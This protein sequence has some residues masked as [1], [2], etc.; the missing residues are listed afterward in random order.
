M[1]QIQFNEQD[2]QT[3][4]RRSQVVEPVTYGQGDYEALAES[5]NSLYAGIKRREFDKMDVDTSSHQ[6]TSFSEASFMEAVGKEDERISTGLMQSNISNWGQ[7]ERRKA[8][9]KHY[10]E[11]NQQVADNFSTAGMLAAGIPMALLDIDALLINPTLAG[12]SKVNKVLNLQTKMSKVASHAI[13]GGLVGAESM[14][15]YELATGV[16][17]DDSVTNSALMGMMLG[18]SLGTFIERAGKPKDL[19]KETAT[20]KYVDSTI[21]KEQELVKA[22]KELDRTNEALNIQQHI[23]A[24]IKIEKGNI[25]KQV[26]AKIKEAEKVIES[27]T[28]EVLY[29]NK[30]GI[31]KP[32][33]ETTIDTWDKAKKGFVNTQQTLTKEL[34]TLESTY[35]KLFTA[36]TKIQEDIVIAEEKGHKTNR[37]NE[38][39]STNKA[40]FDKL[41]K[42]IDKD[43]ANINKKIFNNNKLYKKAE[44]QANKEIA[45]F[46]RAKE[47]IRLYKKA[48]KD[49]DFQTDA[50]KYLDKDKFKALLG[51]R[52]LLTNAIAD[53]QTDKLDLPGIQKE[54]QN[55]VDKLTKELEDANSK[56]LTLEDIKKNKVVKALPEWAQKMLIS[57]I[58][59]LIYS[60]N[61]Y[62]SG[63]ASMLHVGTTHH[64]KVNPRTAYRIRQELDESLSRRIRAFE[65]HYYNAKKEGYN[66]SKEEFET[67]VTQEIYKVNGQLQRDLHKDIPGHFDEVQRAEA[68]RA[69]VGSVQRTY[70]SGNK[71][72]Q[73][74]VDEFLDYYE[75]IHSKGTK[76]E[77]EAFKNSI[78]K[79]YVKRFYDRDKILA[80]GRENA[81]EQLV[82]SQKSYRDSNNLATTS[83][84]LIE[85]RAKAETAVDASIN[86]TDIVTSITKPLGKGH[87]TSTSPFKQRT[88]EAYDDDLMGLLSDDILGNS[89]IYGLTTHGRLA[90][91]EK[92]GV[93]TLDEL[94]DLF[95]STG[96]NAK[97]LDN[98]R[99]VADT[100]MGTREVTRNPFNPAQRAIKA[101]SSYS[102]LM[103]TGA[104]GIPTLT[105]VAS[106]AK[107]FGW[108]STIN[109]LIPSIKEVKD[110]YLKG[111][112]SDKNTME[113]TAEYGS[114]YFTHRAN[115]HDVENAFE[116][117]N[118]IQEKID[119]SVHKL[120]VLG[121]LL[122][123]T[124]VL[125]MTTITSSVD[126]LAK[127]SVKGDISPTDMMRLG[128]MGFD[129]ND[130]INIRQTLKVGNDG[131]INN[132]DRKSW[133][134][135][136]QQIT[137]GVM[138]MLDRTILHPN[139]ATLPKLMT[140]ANEGS[141]VSKILM[142]FMRFPVESYERL[143]MRSIQEADAKQLIALGGNIAMWT[144]ILSAKDA[145]K[146]EEKQKYKGDEG[147]TELMKDS[148]LYNSWT[149]FPVAM[150][151]K[152]YGAMTGE[153]L[154]N[155]Y[156][157]RVLGVAEGDLSSLQQGNPRFSIPLASINI[158]DGLSRINNDILHLDMLGAKDE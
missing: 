151:D 39:L 146:D 124:D 144:L 47:A 84:M 77:L 21:L 82:L 96:A 18:G 88:I 17:N 4:E 81:I 7:Y 93:D 92:L 11:V 60:K 112:P 139:G 143:L 30:E 22:Q 52:G 152:V 31:L 3:Y 116:A 37:L 125:K 26:E 101:V 119:A 141:W 63:L 135:L 121:G 25:T 43:K 114:A 49:N 94:E 97:E 100:I 23:E 66:K 137:D 79:G 147:M 46:N 148:L 86:K 48:I 142:K 156:R 71:H 123:I 40:K 59:N 36:I 32:R 157:H 115:R 105:E 117:T 74:A 131:R 118:K 54:K 136:D 68:V 27:K 154:T 108:S 99:V 44:E 158:G 5:M 87:A 153:N 149:S 85:F 28:T 34:S 19:Y 72:I 109:N 35:N 1:E 69:K 155:N 122:P 95:K 29:K 110:I 64:G 104:F 50:N 42:T 102:S 62:V 134:K 73:G 57:P 128:D 103:H 83:D 65:N 80:V 145:L 107:E 8:Y 56:L 150:S 129:A 38:R 24:N 113:L 67:E 90:L 15:T 140:D 45:D 120:S 12:V 89:S 126:F 111:T 6:D 106:I 9:L 132:M 41:S 98:L 13:A 20:G 14:A 127:M 61:D 33:K 91:K 76:L 16:Y 78:G 58:E 51:K 133:G 138:T 53:I 2:I 70:T 130:L 75:D 10:H 55:Y